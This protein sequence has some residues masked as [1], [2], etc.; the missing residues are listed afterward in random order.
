MKIL[1]VDFIKNNQTKNVNINI[2]NA[3]EKDLELSQV[4]NIEVVSR[5]AE[6]GVN[7]K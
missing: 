5:W 6:T 1:F 4:K 2:L 3:I 7:L